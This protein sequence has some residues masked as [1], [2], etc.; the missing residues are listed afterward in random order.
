[1]P[2]DEEEP[3]EE[4][5][6]EEPDEVPPDEEEPD[7]ELDESVEGSLLPSVAPQVVQVLGADVVA[8][9]QLCPVSLTVFDV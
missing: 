7:E 5:D 4:L 6:E 9:F 2:P 3:D 8:A 1:M